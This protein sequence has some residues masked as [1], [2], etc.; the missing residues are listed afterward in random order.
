MKA[1]LTTLR[2]ENGPHVGKLDP[3]VT[4]CENMTERFVWRAECVGCLFI[5]TFGGTKEVFVDGSWFQTAPAG[6]R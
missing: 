1:I 3:F 4:L 6:A 2:G 5:F